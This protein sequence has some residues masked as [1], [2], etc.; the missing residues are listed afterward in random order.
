[1]P[2]GKSAAVFLRGYSQAAE[3]RPDADARM[4]LEPARR[5][6][7]QQRQLDRGA[8]ASAPGARARQAGSQVRRDARGARLSAQNFHP[9]KVWDE[10]AEVANRARICRPRNPGYWEVRGWSDTC[11]RKVNS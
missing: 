4:H 6:R 3:D 5:H 11:W 7:Y 10:A 9:G 2:G 1:G 8:T